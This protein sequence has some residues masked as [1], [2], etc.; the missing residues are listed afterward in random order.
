MDLIYCYCVVGKDNISKIG[1]TLKHEVGFQKGKIH[2][3]SYEDILAV[4]SEVSNE[5]FS[6]QAIDKNV[7]DIN[8]LTNNAPLH[9]SII[10]SLMQRVTLLPMKFCTIFNNKEQV[11]DM[12]EEKYAHV[13]YFLHH[14]EGK[15]EFGLKAYGNM[16]KLQENV[17]KDSSQIQQLEE[18]KATKTPGHGYFVQQK[19]DLL[20]KAKV[21]QQVRLIKELI[22]GRVRELVQELKKNDVLT[23]KITGKDSKQEM[24]LNLAMLLNKEKEHDLRKVVVSL[25][26]QFP[27][28]KIELSGPFAAY[29]FIR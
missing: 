21:Q 17:K 25:N 20:L 3:I 9:E 14:I 13:K 16:V 6:Q 2:T 10:T 11:V 26:A 29:N 19:I 18:E 23:R 5:E 22:I 15:V 8:W 12:L 7:K 24:V 4:V 27:F 28:C 1:E